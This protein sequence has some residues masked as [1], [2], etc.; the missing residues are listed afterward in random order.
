VAQQCFFCRRRDRS[1][2]PWSI[3]TYIDAARNRPRNLLHW[4]LDAPKEGRAV[5]SEPDQ[6]SR[7]RSRIAPARLHS[8][9]DAVGQNR[10]PSEIA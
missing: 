2:D 1:L 6:S 7:G 10:N 8:M 9:R 3:T 5:R 4:H